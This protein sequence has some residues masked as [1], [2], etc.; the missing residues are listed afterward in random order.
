VSASEVHSSERLKAS[1]LDRLIDDEPDELRDA[2]QRRSITT[3]Q[4]RES[5]VRD[6]GWLLNC[7][8]LSTTQPLDAYPYAAKSV[9]NFGL[10]DLAGRTT[11]SVDAPALERQLRQAV[12][13]FEPR[14]V[15]SSVVVR[16]L[17]SPAESMHN[18][19]Q[20]VIEAMLL[21]HPV[22]LALWLRTEIDLENGEVSI[23]EWER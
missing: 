8:R 21:A 2:P 13:D 16:V 23:T 1:L 20:L 3:K 5:V 18:N 7:V 15:P 10:P 11:T 17:K 4:L 19:L 22:P 6:L 14:L 12:L 9:L